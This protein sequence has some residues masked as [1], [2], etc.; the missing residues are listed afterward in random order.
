MRGS[1]QITED[2]KH[3]I[4]EYHIRRQK[5]YSNTDVEI[6][7][8]LYDEVREF[9]IEVGGYEWNYHRVC[10]NEDEAILEKEHLNR[11]GCGQFRNFKILNLY[12]IWERI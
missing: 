1:K 10:D 4:L 11:T 5:V 8:D 9:V 12:T 6:V 3:K 2:M 7:N